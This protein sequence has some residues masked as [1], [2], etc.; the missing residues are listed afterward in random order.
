[1]IKQSD[2]AKFVLEA[3]ARL[4]RL[5]TESR[6]VA[7]WPTLQRKIRYGTPD[8]PGWVKSVLRECQELDEA[9]IKFAEVLPASFVIDAA[10]AIPQVM[11][12]QEFVSRRLLEIVSRLL[13]QISHDLIL[14]GVYAPRDAVEGASDDWEEVASCFDKSQRY[15]SR[16]GSIDSNDKIDWPLFIEWATYRMNFF[17]REDLVRCVAKVKEDWAQEYGSLIP[18][19]DDLR[20]EIARTYIATPKTGQQQKNK[21][22]R[23]RETSSIEDWLSSYTAKEQAAIINLENKTAPEMDVSMQNQRVRIE[24]DEGEQILWP[25]GHTKKLRDKH[26]LAKQRVSRRQN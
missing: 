25:F 23:P 6:N 21:P 22:G 9:Y 3:G 18:P 24:S 20:M 19:L 2:T 11:S 8:H 12:A 26:R 16:H 7:W 14:F 10:I 4:H 13:W 15:L 1:M 17:R 5:A